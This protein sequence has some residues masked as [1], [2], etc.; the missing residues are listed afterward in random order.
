MKN[1]KITSSLIL[2]CF[3]M[4]VLLTSCEANVKNSPVISPSGSLPETESATSTPTPVQSETATGT[5]T[6]TEMPDAS[7]LTEKVYINYDRHYAPLLCD[8]DYGTKYSLSKGS[9]VTIS[10]AEE[11]YAIYV[12]WD[13]IPGEWTLYSNGETVTGGQ[14][15]FIH[16]YIALPEVSDKAV[17][18]IKADKAVICDIYTFSYGTLPDWV[19]TWQTP[20]EDADMLLLSTHADDE[21][22]YFGGMM[23]YYA[24]ELGL[25]VQVAYLVNHWTEQPR[26]HELLNGL[27]TVGII[28]Y[29][30]I[31]PFADIYS[32]SLAHAK[33]VYRE[34]AVIEYQVELLRRFKPEVVISHDLNGEYGHGGHMLN[35]YCLTLAVG[36]A[37][38]AALYPVSAAEFGT[39]DTPKLYLHL[40]AQ[41][42][43]IMN[44]DIPL[45]RFDQSTAFEMAKEGYSCHLSQ[46]HW[47]FAVRQGESQYDCRRF[48]LYRSLVGPD[49]LKND[50]F[51]N[52]VLSE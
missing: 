12:I 23:P 6:E 5:P 18:T 16:E 11:I 41:N 45:E 14:N 2:L 46:Q 7:D 19:Q 44:W 15:G 47:S 9:Q 33:T 32:D 25:K 21:H 40:Y 3:I 1:H 26:P 51:E 30:I 48:G 27:W 17:I 50:V 29:P 42:E 31:G 8:R 20:W 24:G 22:L 34:D 13:N 49:I 4:S 35:A 38:D 28:A 36:Y 39:W 37:A 52:I 10:A 43:I